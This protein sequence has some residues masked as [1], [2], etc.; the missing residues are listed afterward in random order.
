MLGWKKNKG[1]DTLFSDSD[2]GKPWTP[3]LSNHWLHESINK[4]MVY[5]AGMI[6]N[7]DNEIGKDVQTYITACPELS[8]PGT[9]DGAP[10]KERRGECG[11]PRDS[12]QAASDDKDPVL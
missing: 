9:E 7:P 12:E 11:G 10:S 8:P 4:Y 2:P 5:V 1:K 3:L 6:L